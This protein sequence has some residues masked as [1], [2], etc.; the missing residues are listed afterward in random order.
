MHRALYHAAPGAGILVYAQQTNG[1]GRNDVQIEQGATVRQDQPIFE[2][3]DP[4][5]MR[6]AHRINETKVSHVR[7]GQ[8]R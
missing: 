7:S 6:M 2:L 5:H 3:P 4:K 8:Q 1:W